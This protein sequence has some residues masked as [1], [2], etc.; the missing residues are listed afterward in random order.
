VPE[1]TNAAED[2]FMRG[3]C[4]D[5]PTCA[6]TTTRLSVGENGAQGTGASV[7]PRGNY[8]AWTGPEW[9]TFYSEAT[10]F[11][12]GGAPSPYYGAI[13]RVVTRR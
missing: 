11:W 5:T 7:N 6:R 9:A 13:F 1:D 12:P 4:H 10:N 8:D 3:V 2:V